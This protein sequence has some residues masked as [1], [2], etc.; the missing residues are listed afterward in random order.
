MASN[1]ERGVIEAEII[2]LKRALDKCNKDYL[3]VTGMINNL[4]DD[5]VGISRES[6][7]LMEM[8]TDREKALEEM[9]EA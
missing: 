9:S 5:N 3:I 2:S 1:N 7:L 8:I 6:T 4:I